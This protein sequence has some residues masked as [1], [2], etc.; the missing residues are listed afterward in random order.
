MLTFQLREEVP[1]SPVAP[2]SPGNE[3]SRSHRPPVDPV[4]G[5][6]VSAQLSL[7]L[8]LL[9][10]LTNLW[11]DPPEENV[12]AL[13]CTSW[14]LIEEEVLSWDALVETGGDFYNRQMK[15]CNIKGWGS[16]F[17]ILAPLPWVFLRTLCVPVS[18]TTREAGLWF[19][20]RNRIVS[21]SFLVLCAVLLH[22]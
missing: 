17:S 12:P 10:Y 9:P 18:Q 4:V 16:V 8:C 20:L 3:S 11:S 13:T 1:P 15:S 7:I 21:F 5:K 14:L 2:S 22:P 19:S 6:P